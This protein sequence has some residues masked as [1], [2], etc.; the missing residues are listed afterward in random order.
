MLFEKLTSADKSLISNYIETYGPNSESRVTGVFAS[1]EYRLRFWDKNKKDL[2]RLFGEKLSLEKEIT[3]VIAPEKIRGVIL[4]AM[5]DQDNPMCKFRSVVFDAF[6][7]RYDYY[8]PEYYTVRDMFNAYTL[9]DNRINW[10]PDNREN[11]T[12]QMPNGASLKVQIGMKPLKALKHIAAS[13]GELELYEQFRLEHSRC[14]NQKKLSGILGLSIHPMDFLTMSDNTSNWSSC[15]S[16]FEHGSYRV[17]TVEMM[18]SPFVV[19]G[20]LRSDKNM[21][22]FG[23]EEWNNKHWRSLFIVS[24]QGI[25]SVKG[26]P[27]QHPDLSKLCISWLSDLAK[28]NLNWNMLPAAEFK[29]DMDFVYQPAGLTYHITLSTDDMYNDFGSCDHYAALKV[30]GDTHFEL[31]Y[32]GEASC[33]CCGKTNSTYDESFVFCEFCCTYEDEELCSCYRCGGRWDEDD[34]YWVD[35]ECYCP[36]CINEVAGECALDN[37]YYYLEDLRNVYLPQSSDNPNDEDHYITV[38]RDYVDSE[39]QLAKM[40]HPYY[41]KKYFQLGAGVHY[42]EEQK[43]YYLNRE[44]LTEL[45]LKHIFGIW[46]IPKYFQEI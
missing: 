33:M 14:L 32:S 9:Y 25:I 46:D 15:M 6:K 2:F 20:Y 34:M 40:L 31:T 12:I 23:C 27:Y 39:K 44:D 45:G 24:P 4:N 11:I 3:Y 16:W 22:L 10:L 41:F 28:A 35:D 18:N 43:C 21:T 5:A 29:E 37:R 36:D 38:L 1:L 7:I 30:D 26:Y 17:G 19:V 8:D 42:S 13:L